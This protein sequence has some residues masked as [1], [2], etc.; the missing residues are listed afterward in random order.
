MTPFSSVLEFY[1]K[2]KNIKTYAVAQ[3][4]GIDRSNMYKILNGKR[5]PASENLVRRI[6]DY[7]R[8]LPAER[9][10]LLEA[11]QIT[12]MG[13]RAYYRR[14]S[15]Q[16]FLISFSVEERRKKEKLLVQKYAAMDIDEPEL[17][18]GNGLIVRDRQL[19]YLITS[20]LSMELQKK[21]GRISLIMQPEDDYIGDI[22]ILA[23]AKRDDLTIEHI[24]CLSNT[25]NIV[26]GETDYNLTCLRNILPL[27]VQCKCE[28][29]PYCYYDNIISHNSKFNLLSSMV[30]TSEYAIVFSMEENYGM[31]LTGRDTIRGLQEQFESLKQETGLMAKK[32]DSL[33]KQLQF[34]SNINLAGQGIGF[35]PEACLVPMIPE[36]FFE[37]YLNKAI[38]SQQLL[39]E[40]VY[41]YVIG[42]KEKMKGLK[43]VFIFSETGITKFLKMGRIS[44]LPESIYAPLEYEDRV[45]LIK[46]LIKECESGR[47]R[48]LRAEIPVAETEVCLYSTAC[49]GHLML[50]TVD[51]E[52]IILELRETGLL[53]TFQDYFE[54]L[55]SKCFYSGEE[56]ADVLKVLSK[57]TYI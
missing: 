21:G 19:R 39:R 43:T 30:V 2:A 33:E 18:L 35:Q 9:E 26:S 38:L 22:L 45:V 34:F 16:D 24:F 44:E 27:F 51:G 32:V 10:N 57:R 11:Y 56:A 28:Y 42:L 14:K 50:P 41:E 6:A 7:M 55:D 53:N 1:M 47:Y 31:L 49:G 12:M 40:K 20:I 4:C 25:D 23:G 8:L 29:R 52:R 15:V 17:R 36:E 37:K 13:S 3:F 54:S 5:N 46:R 48:M